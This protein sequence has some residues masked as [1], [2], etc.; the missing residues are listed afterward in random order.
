MRQEEKRKKGNLLCKQ[1][2]Y[3]L[4]K[5]TQHKTLVIK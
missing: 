3:Y 5:R 1:T 4:F 2:I